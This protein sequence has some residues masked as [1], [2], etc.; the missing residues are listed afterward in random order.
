MVIIVMMSD[1]IGY[2]ASFFTSLQFLPQFITIFKNKD[3]N[4]TSLYMIL[5]CII[6]CSLWIIYSISLESYPMILVNVLSLII[7]ISILYLKVK[8][9]RINEK[10]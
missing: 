9:E 3:A 10:S 7:A 2:T 4:Q 6:G 8:Y 1:I 5:F